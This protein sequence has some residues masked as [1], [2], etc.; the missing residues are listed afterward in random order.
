MTIMDNAHTY[1]QQSRLPGPTVVSRTFAL[2][3]ALLLMS[4][5]AEAQQAGR[6]YRI[7]VLSPEVPPPGLLEVF[8]EGLREL[9]YVEGKNVVIESR[10]AGGKNERLAVLADELIRL[11]VD[12]IL[13]VN[14]PAA[15]AAK[16]ATTTI[17]IVMT[18]IADPVKSG[19][20]PSL[21]HPGGNLTGLTFIPDEL[22]A[23]QLQLL[24]EIL[25]RISRVAALWNEGN[26]G[27]TIHVREMEPA[28]AKLGLQLLLLPVR[29]PTDF[30]GAFQA[31]AQG[32]AEALFVQD[33]ALITKHRLQIL[34]LARKHSLP[35]SRCTKTF[36]RPEASSPTG[37]AL[38]PYTDVRRTTW[39]ES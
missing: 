38:P 15:W 6:V 22:G 9:G 39:I 2:V 5:T 11:K 30:L 32:R 27:S 31:A 4:V 24:K 37:R 34:D 29:G 17:P 35:S 14:T 7:G 19:L 16:N 25:P 10:N 13:A 12:V 20:V 8:Q 23:K 33:D 3:L 28:A 36:P 1:L 21:S 26:P 18:R